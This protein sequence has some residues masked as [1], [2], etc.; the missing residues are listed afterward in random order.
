MKETLI[1]F[2]LTLLAISLVFIGL[3]F[4]INSFSKM[5]I[6]EAFFSDKPILLTISIILGICNAKDVFI[7]FSLLF[8]TAS[9]LWFVGLFIVNLLSTRKTFY[10]SMNRTSIAFIC[11]I[12]VG[13]YAYLFTLDNTIEQLLELRVVCAFDASL[14]VLMLIT[15]VYKRKQDLA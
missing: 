11:S 14:I 1:F 4:L 9:V 2:S 15:F 7:L 8:F 10:I 12:L 5:K 3:T 13:I 6:R